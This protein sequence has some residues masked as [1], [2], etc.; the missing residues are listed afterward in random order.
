M[1]KKN[2]IL[3]I[4]S[5][6]L[7]LTMVVA[8]VLLTGCGNKKEDPKASQEELDAAKAALAAAQAEIEKIQANLDKMSKDGSATADDLKKAQEELEAAKK[9]LE[10][11]TA[12]AVTP[13]DVAAAT[14]LWNDDSEDAEFSK[15]AYE[16]K[17]K[18]LRDSKK[19]PQYEAADADAVYAEVIGW[20]DTVLATAFKVDVIKA[21]FA[22]MEAKFEAIV[23]IADKYDAE[24][25]KLT[26]DADGGKLVLPE[27]TDKATQL[28]EL[29][30]LHKLIVDSAEIA[31]NGAT[32]KVAEPKKEAYDTLVAAYE[33]LKTLKAKDEAILAAAAAADKSIGANDPT[34]YVKANND[35]NEVIGKRFD[36][37][38][39]DVVIAHTA[40]DE[41]DYRIV[42][43]L[44]A[45]Y[46]YAKYFAP[47][48][49]NDLASYKNY[50]EKKTRYEELDAASKEFTTLYTTLTNL[51]NF[52][53]VDPIFADYTK[54]EDTDGKKVDTWLEKYGLLAKALIEYDPKTVSDADKA[55]Y[56]EEN[57]K[58][59]AENA[60]KA[61]NAAYI[62]NGVDTAKGNL[63]GGYARVLAVRNIVNTLKAVKEEYV[64][65]AV[66]GSTQNLKDQI[67]TELVTDG[68]LYTHIDTLIDVYKRIADVQDAVNALTY[69]KKAEA[70]NDL[71][72]IQSW[73]KVNQIKAEVLTLI[74]IKE[75]VDDQTAELIATF[76]RDVNK[77]DK[78]EDL[79]KL[80]VSTY[81]KLDPVTE[82][83][84]TVRRVWNKV[85]FVNSDKLTT[86]AAAV[87]AAFGAK[88]PAENEQNATI[89]AN[90]TE[91][92]KE[93][94]A[95]LAYATTAFTN[96][97]AD[98]QAKYDEVKSVIYGEDHAVKAI[99][100]PNM[101]AIMWA[102]S[103]IDALEKGYDADFT[104]AAGAGKFV[105][106]EYTDKDEKK[107]TIKYGEFRTELEKAVTGIYKLAANADAEAAA[108]RALIADNKLAEYTNLNQNPYATQAIEKFIAW[109]VKYLGVE[110]TYKVKELNDK[111]E[112]VEVVKTY[113]AAE[114]F[115]LVEKYFVEADEKG[116]NQGILNITIGDSAAYEFVS[117]QNL[118]YL[119]AVEI[120]AA[121]K[122]EA[123]KAEYAKLKML[124]DFATKQNVQDVNRKFVNYVRTFYFDGENTDAV[125]AYYKDV[126]G[127]PI[128]GMTEKEY[129]NKKAEVQKVLDAERDDAK[130]A[131][132][133]SYIK[134]TGTTFEI[135]K[136]TFV[137]DLT[138]YATLAAFNAKYFAIEDAE[139]EEART[140]ALKAF[141]AAYDY[142]FV[143]VSAGSF[144]AED[145]PSAT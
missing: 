139:T 63:L 4:L 18:A 103:E 95:Q 70:I 86:I 59:T 136:D 73:D 72:G 97:K 65:P 89:L 8:A 24:L 60:I 22:E 123:A 127:S 66:K 52:K 125:F 133:A 28:D 56:D 117:A 93:F 144:N 111:N 67:Q 31:F 105:V 134:G 106:E 118:G 77:D 132:Y 112:E 80:V 6:V 57:L 92:T 121:A 47:I 42:D 21:I 114:Y 7:V 100:L 68:V 116:V 99:T 84:V 62:V 33:V 51:Q 2:T 10:E 76:A 96:M 88:L 143:A 50:I 102:K 5:F 11:L 25:A 16:A 131:R 34:Y 142:E 107:Q 54:I 12:A 85:T 120:A 108:I 55:K 110:T 87:D 26:P 82:E 74:G 27:A 98:F 1:M 46:K 30:R 17:A 141:F 58:T 20:E 40:E 43:I 126:V 135:A 137:N 79:A 49:L 91:I 124:P 35:A 19:T 14:A 113:T 37:K 130:A 48:T 122:Y 3:K 145:Y 44:D 138:A 64:D 94:K 78:E 61:A 41:K 32:E 53:T 38:E 101:K 83:E 36:A 39:G 71:L 119:K 104:N 140:T 75:D 13:E 128:Y 109:C 15:K 45:G 9:A 115:A 69:T 90:Y 23:K 29:K 129:K 81:T